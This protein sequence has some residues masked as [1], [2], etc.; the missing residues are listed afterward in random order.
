MEKHVVEV[1]S[2]QA[3]RDWLA[4]NHG[5]KNGI[6]LSF[7]KK[8]TDHHL[9]YNDI[10]EE[11]LCFGWIDSLPRKMDHD[12]SLLYLSPRKRGSSWSRLNKERI[13][14]LMARGLMTDAGIKKFEQAQQDGS[15]TFLDEVEEGRL[16]EDLV[17]ALSE[18]EQAREYFDAF[19]LSSRKIILEWIK[20]AKKPAT[21]LR[22]IEETVQEAIKNERAHH[23]R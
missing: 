16:P 17:K 11:C 4:K 21:R 20:S 3:L 14:R 5:Q 18:D 2:R 15:W 23:Y 13:A 12:R 10:V 1:K 22:R 8:H 9:P 7:Y 19:P 6:W